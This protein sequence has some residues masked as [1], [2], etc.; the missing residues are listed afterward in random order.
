M[1]IGAEFGR[2]IEVSLATLNRVN[3]S[4]AWLRVDVADRSPHAHEILAK[5]REG[6]CAISVES[7]SAYKVPSRVFIGINS[8][9]LSNGSCCA[10]S[11]NWERGVQA[12]ETS[13]LHGDL[14]SK[15]NEG[16]TSSI[17][18]VSK[19]APEV[20]ASSPTSM[21]VFLHGRLESEFIS[22]A[23]ENQVVSEGS[24][25]LLPTLQTGEDGAAMFNFKS[26]SPINVD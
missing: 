19:E 9:C 6:S 16:S 22:P 14:E 17:K 1:F 5:F 7:F 2:V 18:E 4:E 15:I 10:A 3:L 24:F 20:G 21:E 12:P 23:E 11:S 25:K 26:G 13:F 8:S